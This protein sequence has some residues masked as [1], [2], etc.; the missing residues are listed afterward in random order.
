M[1]R[2]GIVFLTAATTAVVATVVEAGPFSP[3]AGQAGSAAISKSDP[4]VLGWA[5]SVVELSRGPRNLANPNAGLATAGAAGDAL[6]DGASIVSLGDGG[7]ITLGFDRAIV[8]GPGADLVVFEN[9]FASGPAYY[10]ELAF[11]EVSSDGANFFRFDAVSLTPTDVQVGSFG[12]LDPTNLDNLAG[13][14]V[15]GFGVPFD[16]GELTGISPLLD[17]NDVRF[18]RIV[19]VV[20]AVAP[21]L[22]SCDSLGNEVND[23]WPTEFASGGFDLD[24]VGVLH[25]VPEPTSVAIL[26]IGAMA[27]A[28]WRFRWRSTSAR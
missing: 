11:V 20:G 1:L 12:L 25:Q 22:A 8:D 9:G 26:V 19:D 6:G 16:L 3:A 7:S 27:I 15:S 18:V 23:P 2:A 21:A 4:Q 5:T 13:K 14:Y 10:L 17:V 28:R 24:A